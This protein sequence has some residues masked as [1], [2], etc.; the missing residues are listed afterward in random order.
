L[1]E[2]EHGAAKSS[3]P[4]RNKLALAE[5]CSPLELLSFDERA[6]R[7]YG[8]IRTGLERIGK[9]IG[10]LDT[11]IAAQAISLNVILV[12]SNLA[13]FKRVP[14]LKVENWS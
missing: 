5:F 4:L 2:L 8:K 6:A 1:A 10:P 3:D 11:L 14:D 13:E 12:T 7:A 9:P